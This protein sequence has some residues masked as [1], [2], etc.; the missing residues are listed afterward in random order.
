MQ[1]FALLLLALL[2]WQIAAFRQR[3]FNVI[4]QFRSQ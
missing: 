4:D 3:P 2:C 1:S